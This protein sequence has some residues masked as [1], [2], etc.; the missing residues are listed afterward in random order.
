[1][2]KETKNEK[3]EF[4]AQHYYLKWL[5]ALP[6]AAAAVLA[7]FM[8]SRYVEA[9][10]L[11]FYLICL[12]VM[13]AALCIYYT[14]VDKL[15]I[16]RFKGY[17]TD[18]GGSV[19]IELGKKKYEVTDVNALLFGELKVFTGRYARVII[20]TPQGNVKIFGQ[21]LGKKQKFSDSGLF[22]LSEL[23]LEKHSDL[24]PKMIMKE[25]AEGWYEKDG[26]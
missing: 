24:K 26:D 7:E 15:G 4:E 17:Y 6:A 8:I 21:P 9:G 5:G 23:I 20:E 19:D 22:P 11:G 2:A 14:V 16:F 25:Q 18:R 13:T 1:M 10:G 12:A 3:I